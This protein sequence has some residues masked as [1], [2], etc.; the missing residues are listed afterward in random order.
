VRVLLLLAAAAAGV[1]CSSV[2]ASLPAGHRADVPAVRRALVARLHARHLTFRWVACVANG[3]SYRG[4]PIVRCNVNF[5][6]PHIEIYC[7]AVVNG[8][9]R[10]AAWREPVQGRQQREAFARECAAGLARGL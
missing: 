3:R 2:A 10:S 7:A 4:Q 6:D 8:T 5:G 1:A 9:L